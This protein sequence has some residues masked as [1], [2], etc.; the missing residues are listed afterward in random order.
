[1]KNKKPAGIG[2]NERLF[3]MS[4]LNRGGITVS[5]SNSGFSIESEATRPN[6]PVSLSPAEAEAVSIIEAA[7]SSCVVC[8]RRSADY[9]S[10]LNHNGIDFC[11]LKFGQRSSWVSFDLLLCSPE[12][13]DDPLLSGV[14][15][16]KQR[17]WK[18]P[19]SSP[20]ELQKY[21]DLVK[22]IYFTAAY[23]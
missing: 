21:S 5:F 3:V 19:V 17:H 16:K 7:V 2:G 4:S 20:S 8:S 22:A 13:K 18:V 9:L 12:L 14:K 6:D 1:M 23:K 10:V 15:N 11:R